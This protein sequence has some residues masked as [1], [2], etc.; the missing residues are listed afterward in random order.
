MLAPVLARLDAV[1]GISRSRAEASGRFLLLELSPGADP[2][3]VLAA[4]RRALGREARRLPEA[5]A[6]E[7]LAARGRGDP[8]LAAPE[9]MALSYVEGRILSTRVSAEAALEARLDARERDLLAEA[10][11]LEIFAALER[12]HAEG[13]RSSSGW[14]YEAWPAV[15]AAALQRCRPWLDAVRLEALGR[16]LPGAVRRG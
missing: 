2:G 9:V 3:R 11:R 14:F 12:V 10:L 1:P 16:F 4:A 7:Q 5:E 8:W 15:G 13:G 6:R